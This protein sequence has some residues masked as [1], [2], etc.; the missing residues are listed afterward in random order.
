M[1][2]EISPRNV[3]GFFIMEKDIAVLPLERYND[4]IEKE[5]VYDEFTNKGEAFI[6]RSGYFFREWKGSYMGENRGAIQIITKDEAIL[7]MKK[8]LEDQI[9]KDVETSR[10]FDKL[11]KEGKKN[12]DDL[13][14]FKSLYETEVSKQSIKKPWY[15]F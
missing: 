4:L 3:A 8:Q 1:T 6:V 5:K 9:M 10:A 7:G 2:G 14:L 15:K 11:M 13:Q 12:Y